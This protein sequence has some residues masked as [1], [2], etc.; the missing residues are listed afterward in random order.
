MGAYSD[1]IGAIETKLAAFATANTYPM[2]WPGVGFTPTD[3]PYLMG[4]FIP[5]ETNDVGLAAGSANSYSGIYQV[6]VRIPKGTGTAVSRTMVDNLL[7]E[8]SRGSIY[9]GVITEKSW[10]SGS[11]DVD[12]SWYSVPV[13]IRYRSI[14]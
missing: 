12:E 11:F 9:S 3:E 4:S 7:T 5:A 14:A 6:D 13:S 10:A 8:F 2:A 1:I